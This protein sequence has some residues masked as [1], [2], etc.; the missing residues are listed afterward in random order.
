MVQFDRTPTHAVSSTVL[1]WSI[2][3]LSNKDDDDNKN[4]I[5]DL[6]IGR[7]HGSENV[8][9]KMNMR[10][11]RLYRDYSNS[12]TL[13]NVGEPSRSWISKTHI[14]VEKE[15][16]ISSS[17]VYVLSKSKI[18]QF[19]VAVVQKRQGNVQK[20]EMHAQNCCFAYKTYCCLDVLVLVAASDRKV[21]T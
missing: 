13:S 6:T 3:S 15:N 19:Q 11:F 9:S 20:S 18:R 2:G 8:A 5:R 10:S 4:V 14:Q 17:L 7:R 16:K 21:L 12:L 1:K